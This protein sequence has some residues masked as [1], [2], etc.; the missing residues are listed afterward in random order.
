MSQKEFNSLMYRNEAFG[1]LSEKSKER[2][3]ELESNEIEPELPEP[4][5]VKKMDIGTIR[6]T[7]EQIKEL[8]P[9]LDKAEAE[10]EKPGLVLAQV[11]EGNLKVSFIPHKPARAI[12]A[13]V[14]NELIRKVVDKTNYVKHKVAARKQTYNQ[15]IGFGLK[16]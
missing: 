1:N 16:R 11:K 13:I 15:G 4:P 14:D 7:E 9:F 6:L 8:R 2:L 12:K 5:V 10:K 3:A